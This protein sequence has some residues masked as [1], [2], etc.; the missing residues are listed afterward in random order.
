MK[1]L[2]IILAFWLFVQHIQ[3]QNFEVAPTRL[4]FNLEPGQAGQ[5]EVNIVNHSPKKKDYTVVLSDFLVDS[6]NNITYKTA[7][8]TRRTLKDWV[9]ITPAYFSLDPNQSAKINVLIS[10]PAGEAGNA[11]K[12][13]MLFI[14][15]VAERNEMVAAD[16]STRAGVIINPSIGVYVIQAPASYK[17]ESAVISNFRE[18]EKNKKLAVDVK[19]TGDKVLN[20]KVSLIVSNLQTAEELTME[21]VMVTLI[22]GVKKTVELVLPDGLSP[23]NYS[24]TSVLDYSP[25][26][27]LE[28]VLMDYTIQ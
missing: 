28:G 4:D 24:L 8:E 18:T 17:N 22:P 25:D 16:K 11:T 7:G 6:L 15:E 13:G 27:D 5:M 23:G 12:W 2:F 3:A 19:N 21:P 1:A 10:T 26:K 14:Q 9:S 20:A